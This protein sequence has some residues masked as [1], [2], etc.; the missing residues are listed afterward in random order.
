ML[1]MMRMFLF[2]L[3][4]LIIGGGLIV[5][6]L[7]TPM[8]ALTDDGYNLRY[9]LFIL[10]GFFVILPL[11]L[12]GILGLASFVKQRR[13]NDLM[14]T[15]KQGKAIIL[16]LED[17]GTRINDNPRVKML[18]E[19]HFE[20]YQPYQVW[21]KITLPLIRMSQVQVGQEV[22]VLADPNDPQNSKRVALMLK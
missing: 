7:F 17:T 14:E 13:I 10:G 15:G 21:K 20:G 22:A 11:F 16:K 4:F 5:W 8:G 3:P 9:F 6:G 12:T 2:N 1:A 19:M 18:L